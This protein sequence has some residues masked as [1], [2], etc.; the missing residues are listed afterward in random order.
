MARCLFLPLVLSIFLSY[1]PCKGDLGS[2]D[3]AINSDLF[4]KFKYGYQALLLGEHFD[5]NIII[6]FTS[7][8]TLK[9]MVLVNFD[10]KLEIVYGNSSNGVT[11][12]HSDGVLPY[13][14]I[15]QTDGSYLK[16]N[17][18]DII[19]NSSA[20]GSSITYVTVP[21]SLSKP[22]SFDELLD[23]SSSV[24]SGLHARN[25]LNSKQNVYFLGPEVNSDANWNSGDN[26]AVVGSYAEVTISLQIAPNSEIK[27]LE[28]CQD[29]F[30][31]DLVSLTVIYIQ[32]LAI[33]TTGNITFSSA[34]STNITN[35]NSTMVSSSGHIVRPKRQVSGSSLF[36]F[37]RWDI[38]DV[39]NNGDTVAMLNVNEHTSSRLRCTAG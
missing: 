8:L 15:S 5:L 6:T 10:D 3:T 13:Q 4:S 22:G 39:S 27:D 24:S 25:V 11:I 21:M 34:S 26:N 37:L 17:F 19:T 16:I 36:N 31:S 38:G 12:T 18:G 33:P 32:C 35:F 20:N 28:V 1:L 7:N 29:F 23:I 9:C 30:S 14:E 2:I